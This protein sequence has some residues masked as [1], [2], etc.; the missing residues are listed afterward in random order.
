L[1]GFEP[2]GEE[3]ENAVVGE[4]GRQPLQIRTTAPENEAGN[5]QQ[6]E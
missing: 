3:S 4:G 2:A 5:G 6:Q 1:G